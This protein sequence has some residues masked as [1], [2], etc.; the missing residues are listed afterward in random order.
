M[1]GQSRRCSERNDL[2]SGV[3]WLLETPGV[4]CLEVVAMDNVP[5][6]PI[7]PAGKSLDATLPEKHVEVID[8]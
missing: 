4:V 6:E 1:G 7:V 2:I 8:N 3:H 5:V